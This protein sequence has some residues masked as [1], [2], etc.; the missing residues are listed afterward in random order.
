MQ[1][2]LNIPDYLSIEDWKYF[3]SLEHLSDTEKMI[4]MICHLG[5]KDREEVNKWKPAALTQVYAKLL[6]SFQNLEPQFYPIIEIDKQLYGFTP[7]SKMTIGE[8]TD[9]ERLGKDS[10]AN[11]EEILAILYRPIEKHSF[12][13]IKWAF[14]NTYKV[15]L[16]QAE[17]LFKY[18]DTKEYNSRDRSEQSK[19]MSTI[20]AS[21]GLGALS[22]FLVLGSSLSLASSL[23]SLPPDQQMK[24]MKKVQ[25]GMTSLNIGGGLLQFITSLEHPS[26]TSQ[27]R[28]LSLTSISS[29]YLTSSLTNRIRTSVMSSL[30]NNKNEHTV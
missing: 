23:S 28:K 2:E 4:E 10:V 30:E 16:G 21:F 17:N 1:I 22:F 7:I 18:Y 8:Y 12:G 25:Q 15:G 6:E 19:L 20:P 5:G 27:E 24:E 3:N 11:L 29:S 26:L 14:K 9:L 13:G